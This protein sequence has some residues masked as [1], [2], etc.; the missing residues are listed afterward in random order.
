MAKVRVLKSWGGVELPG[1][2]VDMAFPDDRLAAGE[3]ELVDPTVSPENAQ[4]VV[5]ETVEVVTEEPEVA[6]EP[7]VEPVVESSA[8]VSLDEGE[9]KDETTPAV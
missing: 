6:P 1:E 3:V 4:P 8:A 9:K 2:V 7:V 5:E